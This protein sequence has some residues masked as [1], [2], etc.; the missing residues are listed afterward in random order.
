M[1][2]VQ[3]P[4]AADV[5]RQQFGWLLA[6]VLFNA[7]SAVMIGYTNAERFIDGI[8]KSFLWSKGRC[9][10]WSGTAFIVFFLVAALATASAHRAVRISRPAGGSPF[11]WAR[12]FFWGGSAQLGYWVVAALANFSVR[13][14]A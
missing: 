4:R 14:I 8:W 10:L 1:V 6:A 13:C 9:A 12:V 7:L 3:E 5:R 2:G 11:L